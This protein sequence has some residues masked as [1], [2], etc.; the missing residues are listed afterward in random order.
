MRISRKK[1]DGRHLEILQR[2]TFN[3]PELKEYADKPNMDNSLAA[4][5]LGYAQ[6][7]RDYVY[8]ISRKT[9]V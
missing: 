4:I 7:K 5:T 9:I 3:E 8:I 1:I 2:D 6:A